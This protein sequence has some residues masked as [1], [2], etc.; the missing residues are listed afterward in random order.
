MI[1]VSEKIEFNELTI[2]M[3]QIEKFIIYYIKYKVPRY[4]Y[5]R[6]HSTKNLI[7]NI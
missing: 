2:K 3:N 7:S 4:I 1:S 6:V 5:I